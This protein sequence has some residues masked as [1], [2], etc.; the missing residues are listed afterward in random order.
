MSPTSYQAAPPRECIIAKALGFVKPRHVE[1]S[2]ATDMLVYR[3]ASL[4]PPLTPARRD[5]DPDRVSDHRINFA[6]RLRRCLCTGGLEF[7]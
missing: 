2:A 1:T 4:K 6:K 3:V 7:F 5:W